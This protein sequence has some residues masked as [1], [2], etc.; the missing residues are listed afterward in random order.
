MP[1][2]GQRCSGWEGLPRDLLAV[3]LKEAAAGQHGEMDLRQAL[4]LFRALGP[5]AHWASVAALE[6]SGSRRPTPAPTGS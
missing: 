6:V 4:Q 1:F 2:R 5:C 3:C